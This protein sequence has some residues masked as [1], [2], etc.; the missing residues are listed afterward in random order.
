MAGNY[1]G[2]YDGI[3]GGQPLSAEKVTLALNQMEKVANKVSTAEWEANTNSEQTSDG[4]YPTCAAVNNAVGVVNTQLTSSVSTL[5]SS[6]EAMNSAAEKT[7][8]KVTQANWSSNKTNDT[9]YPT[10]AAVNSAVGAISDGAERTANRVV[11]SEWGSN[12]TDDTKY[13]TCGA[14]KSAID[15]ALTEVNTAISAVVNGE[16]LTANERI[17]AVQGELTTLS[18]AAE[19]ISNKVITSEWGSNKDSDTKYPTCAAVQSAIT[20]AATNAVNS[21]VKVTSISSTS[22]DSEF[23]SAKA[24]YNCFWN[25]FNSL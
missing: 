3:A 5:T 16:I 13:P 11:T 23:P 24:V 10:C 20:T 17:T 15:S 19:Q 12:N 21:I 6:I 2:V 4:K 25:I 18:G 8:N 9:K 22:T 1:S 7:A 14:V